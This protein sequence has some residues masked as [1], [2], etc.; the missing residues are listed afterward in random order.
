MLYQDNKGF[1]TALLSACQAGSLIL[2]SGGR[3]ARHLRHRY[4]ESQMGVGRTGWTA[5]QV[6][7][8]NAW[9]RKAWDMTWPPTYPLSRVSC[10]ALWKE[11]C[12][13]VPPPEPFQPDYKLFQAVD[14]T[15][16]ALVRHGLPTEGPPLSASP[17]IAWRSEIMKTFEALARDLKG[18][19]PAFLP[20]FLARIIREGHIV[21]PEA[22]VLAAFETPA[23][24]EERLF[25][26]MAGTCR[27]RRLDLPVGTPEKTKRTAMPN[28]KQEVAW[29]TGQ[30]V[31][32]ARTIPL[33]RIGVVV[34]DAEVYVPHIRDS[35]CEI[36]GDSFGESWSAYNIAVGTSL[37]ER[38]LVQSGLLP[39]R[40]WVEGQPRTALLSLVLSTY[41]GRWSMDRDH[42]ARVDQLWRRHGTDGGLNTLLGV[43]SGQSPELFSLLNEGSP[44]LEEGLNSFARQAGRTGAEWVETLESFWDVFGFP[45]VAD[46]A[47][48]GA[49]N[50]L[51]TLLH[52]IR[53]DIGKTRMSL[54]DF[55]DLL[56][57]LLSEEMV[58]ISGNEEAGIQV[59][60]II[61][62]RGLD[63]D[64][65]YVL[66]LAAGSL[67]KPVRPLPLL[68]PQER[69]SVLGATTE[70]QYH[71]AQGAFHH[72]LACAPDITLIRPEEESAEP[73]APSP[74]WT[75]V[76][77]D[78]TH[79]RVDIWN[80]PDGVSVRAAWLQQ[81]NKGMAQSTDFPPVDSPVDGHTIPK[82]I[83]VSALATAFLCPFR[84]FAERVL[85]LL[86]L[87][88]LIMGISPLERGNLLHR[89]LALFTRR[90]RDQGLVGERNWAAMERLLIAC[91]DE[92]LS[93]A[94][95]EMLHIQKSGVGQ[96]ARTVER[97]RWLGGEG[98]RQGL[99]TAWL[100]L[101]G[102]RLD[103]GWRWLCEEAS[104]EGLS[105]P[106]WPFAIAG[107][108]DRIDYHTNSG[109]ALW[110]YKSGAIPTRKDA[111]EHLVDPQILAYVQAA[112]DSRIPE[113]SRG[114]EDKAHISGGYIGLRAASTV[115]LSEFINDEEGSGAIL[116]GWKEAVADIGSKLVSG[117]F[118]AEPGHVS[119]GVREEKA[120]RH[121]PY[122]PLCGKMGSRETVR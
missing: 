45:V 31:M 74:F 50:H 20:V 104:F 22:V 93:S 49:W 65:L 38:S 41:Y 75:N 71:F 90:C 27:L 25:D 84:F 120:C 23:P 66:G 53:E 1:Q 3:L 95:G 82:T 111:V 11:A 76:P 57:H 94:D 108:V 118:G 64:K 35:F 24:T 43:I 34:P 44:T 78:E 69:Q 116:R 47:D 56:S 81:A 7:S 86:P 103:E 109:Y 30:L 21:L 83:S 77:G 46:E 97:S 2:T 101:E 80:A 85:E 5:P 92:V 32:D 37:L 33:N 110:D 62:S 54:A 70:S 88:E 99:L 9:I 36:M 58:H 122:R 28:R 87:E 121:C 96:H 59:L 52:R 15:Y 14:E 12:R 8:L 63:F 105:D 40:F 67:P 39:L 13:R 79:P 112:M 61:E 89:V 98:G 51:R 55:M 102:E 115:V 6:F 4:R 60:G 10:L 72:L 100:R 18:F 68:D 106:D 26:T 107:R 91:S 16:T 117:Q 19:H 73:L 48:T 119:K 29:L 113:I 42:V 17:L 114:T